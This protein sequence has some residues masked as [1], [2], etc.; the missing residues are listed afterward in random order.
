ML[1]SKEKEIFAI[2]IYRV[3][4]NSFRKNDL[5]LEKAPSE[6]VEEKHDPRSEEYQK[7]RKVSKKIFAK[8][9]NGELPNQIKKRSI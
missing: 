2:E 9:L 4:S 1:A 8:A 5:V 6:W 7:S 3:Y